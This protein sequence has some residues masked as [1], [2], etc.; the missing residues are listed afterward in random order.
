[1]AVSWR[2][3]CV[4]VCVFFCASTNA[5][6]GDGLYANLSAFIEE[7]RETLL[8]LGSTP[9]P[10]LIP[11]SFPCALVQVSPEEP[12]S[13]HH[14]R[15]SDINVIASLGDSITAA[16]GAESRSILDLF[17]E[18]RGVSW[19]GGG[20]SDYNT[21]VSM[22]NILKHFNPDLY[23]YATGTGGPNTE[24]AVFNIAVSGAVAEDLPA[25]ARQLVDLMSTS[26]AI[27]FT[28]DWKVITLW[29]GGNDLC[30]ACNEPDR[31]A[32]NMYED[33]LLTTL[34]ILQTIP[35]VYVNLVQML[36]ITRLHE[37]QVGLC[38][39]YHKTVCPCVQKSDESRALVSS[40]ATQYQ[41]VA[42]AIGKMGR[43]QT[44]T[45]A[46]NIQPFFINTQIP[47]LPDG[48]PDRSY[49]APDCFHFAQ[50]AHAVAA[51]ALWNN[52]LEPDGTKQTSWLV[53]QVPR[54]PTPN[55]PFL[56]TPT[57]LCGASSG[58][59]AHT[60]TG[61]LAPPPTLTVE[62]RTML[63]L[64]LVLIVAVPAAVVVYLRSRRR[65]YQ[66]L[67]GGPI[68]SAITSV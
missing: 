18:F 14:L 32:A 11:T 36:D 5:A 41:E 16:F 60:P 20:Q 68:N 54:C 66:S 30:A 19:S 51:V 57:N 4:F 48:A 22:P 39:S 29:I 63:G 45:F 47:K 42:N 25:Q 1:M 7:N 56:C 46:V 2:A 53:G 61:G 10:A 64:A 43:F 15:P 37:V 52:M 34:T 3:L 23:G 50:K 38:D 33:H 55:Q 58:V 21:I 40:Y 59:T 67:S 17:K 8:K 49:L 12:A 13:V 27:N 35:R 31:Y 62:Q 9:E 28:S 44:D 65:G 24:T 6:G 26:S